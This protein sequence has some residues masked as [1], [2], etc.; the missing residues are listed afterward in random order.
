MRRY[1]AMRDLRANCQHV[2]G[3]PKKVTIAFKVWCT[4]CG[5]QEFCHEDGTLCPYPCQHC[6]RGVR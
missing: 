2:W 5:T 4:K 6:G 3:P 1:V